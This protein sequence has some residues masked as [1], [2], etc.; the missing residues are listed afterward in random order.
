MSHKNIRIEF[1]PPE[2]LRYDSLGDWFFKDDELIIQ[3]ASMGT[4]E[5]QFLVALHE[6]VE[7][8]LCMLRGITQEQVDEFDFAY[9]GDEEPGD[10]ADAPYRA[11]HRQAMIIEILMANFMGLVGYGEVK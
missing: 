6:L 4:E 7:V 11:E 9:K 10:Q 5:E 2:K 3:V 8:R 1:V